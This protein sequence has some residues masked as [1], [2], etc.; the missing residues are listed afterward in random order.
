MGDSWKFLIDFLFCLACAGAAEG[1]L[2]AEQPRTAEGQS[3]ICK[4]IS[5]RKLDMY[6]SYE[7]FHLKKNYNN[8]LKELNTLNQQGCSK[9]T[10]K[11]FIILQNIYFYFNCSALIII[12]NVS[13]AP[14]QYIQLISE[15]SRDTED[16]SNDAENSAI[17]SQQKMHFKTYWNRKLLL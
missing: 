15:G 16:R 11:T 3:Y 2:E 10:V 8:F 7:Y 5:S 1:T 14:D 13:W 6:V 9:E 17:P 4:R 12:R